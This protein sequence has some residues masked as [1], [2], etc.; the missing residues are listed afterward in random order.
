MEQLIKFLNERFPNGIQTFN[1]RNTAG[2]ALETI[3]KDNE[4]I[5]DWCF[6]WEYIEIFG[7]TA[8]Q[9][10]EVTTKTKCH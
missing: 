5:V 10:K 7:L 4:I 6:Y 1:T 8:E 3:Y 9:F 2:D